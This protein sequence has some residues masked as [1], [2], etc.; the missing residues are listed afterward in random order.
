MAN[1]NE[2]KNTPIGCCGPIVGFTLWAL[3]LIYAQKSGTL[4]IISIFSDW[5]ESFN[6]FYSDFFSVI[7]S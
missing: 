3:G 4:D 1:T 2:N 5:W 7:F 6:N